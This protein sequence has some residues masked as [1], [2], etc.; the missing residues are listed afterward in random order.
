MVYCL[1]RIAR[2]LSTRPRSASEVSSCYS[3]Y[4]TSL[5]R[6]EPSRPKYLF[7]RSN[8]ILPDRRATC[9][10]PATKTN[11]TVQFNTIVC[12]FASIARSL[13][14]RPRSAGEVRCPE[15]RMW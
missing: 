9:A 4:P 5:T 12:Y 8:E 6:V 2:S 1:A 14:T 11:N 10:A 15:Q 13:S 7:V 3:R